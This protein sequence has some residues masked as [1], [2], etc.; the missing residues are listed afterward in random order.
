M[1]N[2][3]SYFE[4]MVSSP[5]YFAG[6]LGHGD[7]ARL[8]RPQTVA[9][10]QGQS[11]AKVQAGQTVSMALTVDGKVCASSPPPRFLSVSSQVVVVRFRRSGHGEEA[12][13]WARGAWR[14][15]PSSCRESSRT[16]PM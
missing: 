16:W 3:L 10:L 5:L 15:A 12:P 14:A 13:V 4:K 11:I 9:A 8:Y 2:L 7:T 1:K 6:K